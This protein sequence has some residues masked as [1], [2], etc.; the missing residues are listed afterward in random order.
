ML[1]ATSRRSSRK[2]II[3]QQTLITIVILQHILLNIPSIKF[4]EHLFSGSGVVA[5]E[6][7]ESACEAHK[8][9]FLF[10]ISLQSARN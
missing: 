9:I 1:K 2:S 6:Y 4:L 5:C 10:N 8:H 7:T 3:N